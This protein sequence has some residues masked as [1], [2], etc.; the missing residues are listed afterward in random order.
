MRKTVL[1]TT[2]AL[3]TL[4]ALPGAVSGE[5]LH[6]RAQAQPRAAAPGDLRVSASPVLFRGLLTGSA[7]VTCSVSTLSGEPETADVEAFVWETAD[8][9]YAQAATVSGVAS[10][11]GLPAANA[12][13][14]LLAYPATGTA[15]YDLWNLSWPA[16]GTAISLRPGSLPMYIYR[17]GDSYYNGWQSA[18][19]ELLAEENGQYYL[20]GADIPQNGYATTGSAATIA[21]GPATL[22]EGAI[23]YWDDEGAELPVAG[24]A[25]APGVGDD[26]TPLMTDQR[27]AHSVWVNGWA[28][29]RPG[30]VTYLVFERFPGGWT[31]QI[32]AQASYPDTAPVKSFGTFTSGGDKYEG[33]K[34]TIPSTVKPG[35]AY[36][37]EVK[38][39]GGPLLLRTRFQTCT[40]AASKTTV[41]P[42]GA[43]RLSG[44]IPT[45]GHLGPTPGKVKTVVLY[46]R[47]KSAGQPQSWDATKSGWTK[48][49]TLKTDRYGKY[50]SALLHPKR[51]TWYVVRYPAD[52]WYWGA[53]TSVRKV[54]V[55]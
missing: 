9:G 34:I 7:T 5:P 54:T 49:G 19:V 42:G 53:F 40:L 32:T 52:D 46:K 31:N 11:T 16:E 45:Q 12:N 36:T 35:Y 39:V 14:E 17:S 41:S 3:L 50:R 51:S 26:P 37:F 24:R 28:S 4:L 23:Y 1:A 55:R 30:A 44:V 38:H 10:L 6:R 27:N 2:V 13:G 22:D 25:I 43:V 8:I 18:W 33:K 47:T 29:G 21:L 15:L 20:A 48:V